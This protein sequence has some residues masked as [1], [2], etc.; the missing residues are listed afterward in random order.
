MSLELFHSMETIK[1]LNYLIENNLNRKL[2]KILKNGLRQMIPNL[3]QIKIP[4]RNTNTKILYIQTSHIMRDLEKDSYVVVLHNVI[5]ELNKVRDDIHWTILSP[6]D[7]K[8]L[9]FDNT[10]QIT[11]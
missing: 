3:V 9:T 11:D 2:E 4:I 5:K 10:T 1:M 8:S 7:V 6:T